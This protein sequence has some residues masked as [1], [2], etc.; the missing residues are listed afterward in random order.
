[1]SLPTLYDV[2]RPLMFPSK[3]K[4]ILGAF[5]LPTEAC[6]VFFARRI[7]YE[8]EHIIVWDGDYKLIECVPLLAKYIPVKITMVNI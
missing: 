6:G 5:Q 1:M 3:Q 8:K 4:E 7:T 2:A